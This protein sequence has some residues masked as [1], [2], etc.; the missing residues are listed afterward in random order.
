MSEYSPRYV[1][2]HQEVSSRLL[3]GA[4]RDWLGTPVFEPASRA[5]L[6]DFSTMALLATDNAPL[7]TSS[8]RG[9]RYGDRHLEYWL[10]GLR[11]ARIFSS[12]VGLDRDA[13]QTVLDFGGG[14]ARI[15][16]HLIRD[17]PSAR[18]ILSDADLSQTQTA[19]ATL[20]EA[21]LLAFQTPPHP[22]LPLADGSVDTIVA[23]SA[24]SGGRVEAGWL[25][26]FNRVLKPNGLLYLTVLGDSIWETLSHH[27]IGATLLE[28]PAFK[29][30]HEQNLRL[31]SRL[32]YR[33]ASDPAAF[34]VVFHP[35]ETIRTVWGQI[36]DIVSITPDAHEGETAVL[37]R[38]RP[39]VQATGEN[40]PS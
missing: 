13:E 10:S 12:V 15:T 26:E 40:F 27:P 11:D 9:W 8:A 1:F 29:A 2:E 34:T 20:G 38:A 25:L 22:H 33:S 32:A 31:P 35:A 28:D 23:L 17:C 39:Q 21:A 5:L 36:L 18:L 16:R 37:M 3:P 24:F 6:R 14:P 7:P 4:P 19:L 30:F